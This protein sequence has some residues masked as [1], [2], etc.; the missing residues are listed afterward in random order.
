[1]GCEH[2]AQ[3]K[4]QQEYSKGINQDI[5]SR[6]TSAALTE[7]QPDGSVIDRAPD[8]ID[9]GGGHFIW[10]A[11]QSIPLAELAPDQYADNLLGVARTIASTVRNIEAWPTEAERQINLLA[12]FLAHYRHEPPF[13]EFAASMVK[14]DQDGAV[15][16]PHLPD[17]SPWEWVPQLKAT[18]SSQKQAE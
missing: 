9:Q 3:Y 16:E 10:L 1:M 17:K 12:R 18:I 13:V 5:A 15:I 2:Q 6:I 7:I 14:I 11:D 4:A 8:E